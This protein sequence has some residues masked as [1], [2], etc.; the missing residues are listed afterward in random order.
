MNE[1]QE[2]AGFFIRCVALFIDSIIVLLWCFLFAV[3]I[4]VFYPNYSDNDVK[5][6]AVIFY[7]CYMFFIIYS[8]VKFAGTPG[9]LIVG[10]K[11]VDANTGQNLTFFQAI[12]R[13]FAWIFS[14]FLVYLGFLWIFIDKRNQGWHDKIAKTVVISYNK[15]Q[16]VKFDAPKPKRRHHS[17]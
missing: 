13:Y 6:F 7:T 15:K 8:Q 14:H 9:K 2:Y 10:L 3:F 17:F 11:V 5:T 1:E 4:L 12:I 16:A